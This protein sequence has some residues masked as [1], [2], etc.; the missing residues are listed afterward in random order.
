MYERKDL[1]HPDGST[2]R[3][4]ETDRNRVTAMS[5]RHDSKYHLRLLTHKELYP[6]VVDSY[7]ADFWNLL[8]SSGSANA[9]SASAIGV[10]WRQF[11]AEHLEQQSLADLSSID[12]THN[13]NQP[14]FG[15]TVFQS[16]KKTFSTI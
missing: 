9:A 11:A 16:G 15:M 8:A 1:W 4:A 5:R 14:S 13:Y 12:T 10:N 7:Q 3:R 6:P 2:A